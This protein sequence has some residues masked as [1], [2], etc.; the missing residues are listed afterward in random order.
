VDKHAGD[1]VFQIEAVII[2]FSINFSP[3][4]HLSV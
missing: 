3:S 2:H 1:C 4:F